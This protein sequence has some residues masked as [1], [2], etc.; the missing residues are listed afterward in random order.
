MIKSEKLITIET[1][2]FINDIDRIKKTRELRNCRITS[3]RDKKI[4]IYT[5]GMLILGYG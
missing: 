1:I 3:F 2:P 4:L 5:V